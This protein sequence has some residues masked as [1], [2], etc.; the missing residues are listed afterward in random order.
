M[1]EGENDHAPDG[2]QTEAGVADHE[3]SPAVEV[4]PS[5]SQTSLHNDT[6]LQAD[7]T[8]VDGDAVAEHGPAVHDEVARA[9]E[10]ETLLSDDAD[11]KVAAIADLNTNGMWPS[12]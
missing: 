10:P 11:A 6:G 9:V 4:Q 8:H 1:D 2:H 5:D 12:S 7:A 3:R